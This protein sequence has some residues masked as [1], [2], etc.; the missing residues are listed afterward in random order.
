MEKELYKNIKS[1]DFELYYYLLENSTN[2]KYGI[3]IDKV[4]NNTVQESS[5]VYGICKEKQ[6]VC[7][8]LEK[9]ANGNVT[10][11]TLNDVVNDWI[12]E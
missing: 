1:N 7:D 4:S 5:T 9:I 3:E 8:L 11:I 2:I 10:P 12:E 6:K